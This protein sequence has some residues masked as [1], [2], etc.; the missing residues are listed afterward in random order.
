MKANKVSPKNIPREAYRALEDIV[1]PEW[2]SE[3]RAILE[4]GRKNTLAPEVTLSL[5]AKDPVRI[6]A[7]IVLPENTEQIQAIVRVAGRYRLPITPL[8]NG[9]FGPITTSGT[10]PIHL[11]RMDKM[12]DSFLDRISRCKVRNYSVHCQPGAKT[13]FLILAL[14]V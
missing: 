10:V 4:A 14:F 5:H 11:R 6:P 7:C 9:Q 2:I 3:D 12:L 8:T 13:I 1:G